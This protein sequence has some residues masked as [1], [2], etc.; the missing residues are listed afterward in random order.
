[1]NVFTA[2]EPL[3]NPLPGS[4]PVLKKVC[5]HNGLRTAVFWYA[6]AGSLK[7]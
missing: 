2:E 1:L 6:E 4:I 7:I 5:L 3:E